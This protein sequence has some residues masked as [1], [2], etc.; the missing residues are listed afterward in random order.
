MIRF[1][2][3]QDAQE[4][5]AI[6]LPLFEDKKP[7]VVADQ[8]DEVFEGLLNDV[9]RLED[10]EGKKGQTALLYTKDATT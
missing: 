2:L 8:I 6:I 10:F 1:S 7:D 5:D 9:V 3:A 4:V